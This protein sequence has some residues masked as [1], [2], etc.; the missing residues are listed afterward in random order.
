MK[1]RNPVTLD[2]IAKAAGVGKS[3]VSL[4][5]RNHPKIS[6]PMRAKINRL[7]KE[8]G[9]R[10]NPLVSAHMS[11]VRGTHPRNSGQTIAFI[12][13]RSLEE[14]EKDFR[15][16]LRQYYRGAKERATSLGYTLDY[17]NLSSTGMSERRLSEILGARGIH[18]VI[19][20]PLSEGRG[21]QGSDLKW[22]NFASVMI[23]H[24]FLEPRLH[25]SCLDE[26][27][28]VGRL[29]QRLLDYGFERLGIALETHMDVHANHFWLAGYEAY[30]ALIEKENRI[31]H[32]ITQDWNSTNF[33]SWYSQYKPDAIITCNDDIVHW[34]RGDGYD[35]PE[36]VSC[37]TLYW[38]EERG[39]LSGL[40]QNHEL[41]AANAV[42][43]VI[44]Q[45]NLN[46]RGI[47]D[48]HKTMLVQGE[49]RDG[50]TLERRSPAD[51]K[52]PLRI[53]TR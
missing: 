39:F 3:T 20:A 51:Y 40:Y 18:G 23:E 9:Y 32:F 22:E 53:W 5:L 35:V 17:F 34:L 21:L 8:M 29:I 12:A 4:A 37:V 7:A 2:T 45:L 10:P 27:S 26:F 16:P 6:E 25:C 13:N 19:I 1:T 49:W 30:Q 14:A 47:P 28:T 41:M 31:P 48:L 36:E 52:S 38:R 33:L 11:H 42:D 44:S 46:E 24:A 15:R 50:V 43:L